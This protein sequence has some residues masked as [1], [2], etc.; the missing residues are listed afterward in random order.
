MYMYVYVYVYVYMYI[1]IY[2]YVYTSLYYVMVWPRLKGDQHT[3]GN[4]TDI[5]VPNNF[6][7][8]PKMSNRVVV[9]TL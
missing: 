8:I 1:Y 2:I 4:M 7:F 9:W 3:L 5:P 6:H